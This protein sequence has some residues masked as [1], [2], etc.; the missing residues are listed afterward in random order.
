M[1]IKKN[2]IFLDWSLTLFY[3][4]NNEYIEKESELKKQTKFLTEFW[5]I[6]YKVCN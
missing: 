4:T 6:L 5:I 2:I 1:F 3:K